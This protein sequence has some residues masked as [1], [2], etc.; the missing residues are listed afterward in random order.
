M[1]IGSAWFALVLT[2]LAIG[3]YVLGMTTS[4]R[5]MVVHLPA[6]LG[7]FAISTDVNWLTMLM[8]FLVAL[9]GM[10]VARYAYTYLAG[11]VHEGRFHR[12]LSLTLGSFLAMVAS[13]NLWSFLLFWVLASLSLHRLLVFYRERPVAVLAGRKEYLLHRIADVCLFV[14]FLL[15]ARTLHTS[16]FAGIHPAAAGTHGSLPEALQVASGLLVLSATLKSAQ[17]PFHGWL[18]QVMEA[19]TPVSALLHAGLI[20]TGAFLLL[21]MVPLISRIAW[22]GDALSLIGLVSIVAA[23]LMMITATTI[24]GSLA[25]STCGQVGFMLMECGVGLY[26]LALLHIVSHAVYKAHAFLSSG[27][28]VDN[29]RAPTLPSVPRSVTTGKKTIGSLAFSALIV[30]GT[31]LFFGVPLFQ[32]VPLLVMGTILT[33]AVSQLLSHMLTRGAAGGRRFVL[34]TIFL[35]VLVSV[36]YFGLDSLC[37]TLFDRIWP[38]PQ[39][40]TGMVQDVLLVLIVVVF[41]G[42]LLVQQSIPR[43][44]RRPFWQAIYVHLYNDLYIDLTVTQWVRRL[45]LGHI[46][47]PSPA[48]EDQLPDGISS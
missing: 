36:A 39:E 45:Q 20:Y 25:Y 28:V 31:G 48:R 30:I 3:S 15:I 7:V 42:L 12:W 9:V 17:F 32:R 16:E 23:S 43:L 35:A 22:T 6:Q 38:A 46:V 8:L 19:P 18:I 29:F 26:S 24:K 2:V 44:L 14:A 4:T 47:E 13:G 34:T 21:R 40:A 27:S 41:M 33:V 1:A 11:D 5:Y 37:T 10:I